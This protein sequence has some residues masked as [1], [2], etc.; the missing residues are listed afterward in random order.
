[1]SE[2]HVRKDQAR[3]RDLARRTLEAYRSL[4][5]AAARA[6]FSRNA[7]SN[8]DGLV[9]AGELLEAVIAEIKASGWSAAG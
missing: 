6:A 4:N 5:A 2:N 9:Q 8:G 7:G 1:L 3:L